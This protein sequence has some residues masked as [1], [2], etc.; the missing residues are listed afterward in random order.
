MN[1]LVKIDPNWTAEERAAA[2]AERRR[3]VEYLRSRDPKF[4]E[5]LGEMKSRFG[6]FDSVGYHEDK[7][8]TPGGDEGHRTT[9]TVRPLR[10]L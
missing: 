4:L 1:L 8:N 9:T 5:F 2:E 3:Q 10:A 6:G 7:A